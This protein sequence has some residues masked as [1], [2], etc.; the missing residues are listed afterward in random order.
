MREIQASYREELSRTEHFEKER[1]HL[2]GELDM[3]RRASQDE[4]LYDQDRQVVTIESLQLTVDELQAQVDELEQF[5]CDQD[6]VSSPV[7]LAVAVA[8][9]TI[10]MH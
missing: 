9:C 6:I 4:S 7:L 5:V 10:V 2:E 3:L 1:L 8:A